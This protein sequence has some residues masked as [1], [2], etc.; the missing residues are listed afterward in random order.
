MPTY[1][2]RN[3]ET[4][5]TFDQMMKISERDQFLVDNPNLE[6]LI[7]GAPMMMDPVRAG[8]R[9]VDNGFKEVLHKIH[10]RT[11]GSK[12]DL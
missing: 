10:T 6:S 12:L 3:K 4:G 7:V 11:P 5:E 1:T 9:K 2:F 8:V